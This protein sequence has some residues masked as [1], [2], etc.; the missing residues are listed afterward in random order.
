MTLFRLAARAALIAPLLV[1]GAPAAQAGVG[2]LL[3]APT[4]IVLNGSRGTEI[5]LNNIGDAPARYRISVEL[6]RMK[7]DGTL[8]DVAQ[9]SA[10]EIKARDMILY[11]PRQVTLPPKQPQTI[12]LTARA[13]QGL[14]DGEYRVHLLFRA[15]PPPRS[16]VQTP[17]DFKGIGFALTPIYGVTIPVI[18]RF[19][20]LEAQAGISNVH[21]TRDESGKPAVALDLSRAGRRSTFGEIRVMKAGVAEP[22]AIQRGVAVYTEIGKRSVQIPVE[23][24]FAAQAS[25]PVTVQY[26][27]TGDGIKDVI[28]ETSAVLN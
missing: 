5:I 11:A 12:K 13:P 10:D 22:I 19:G 14:P 24:R 8:E 28:A 3:V 7:P 4:R 25:G 21:L 23:E 6:R 9:P 17:E 26:V 16:A 2:D 18:V 27:E 1:A 15:V 20:N